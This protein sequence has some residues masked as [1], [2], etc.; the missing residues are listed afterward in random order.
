MLNNNEESMQQGSYMVH[1]MM[2][3]LILRIFYP[4]KIHKIMKIWMQQKDVM[5]IY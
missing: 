4:I 3:K 2:M 1:Y 5:K